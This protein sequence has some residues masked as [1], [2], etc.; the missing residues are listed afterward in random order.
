V[1]ARADLCSVRCP[2]DDALRGRS[3]VAIQM[4]LTHP[5]D[6]ESSPLHSM[7]YENREYAL[8]WLEEQREA[9]KQRHSH[10]HNWTVAAAVAG[11]IAAITGVIAV[12]QAL[13]G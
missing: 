4:A 3:E 13:W 5:F 2:H 12:W 6:V 10:L 9:A 8:A 7:R 1:V 11:I